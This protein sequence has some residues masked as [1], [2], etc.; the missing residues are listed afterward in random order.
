MA[1]WP[2][3]TVDS[4]CH[5]FK[6]KRFGGW[7]GALEVARDSGHF[8]LLD[9]AADALRQAQMVFVQHWVAERRVDL[10]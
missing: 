5:L 10:A 2:F 4:S 9:R 8:L 6:V 3:A 7:L 1:D